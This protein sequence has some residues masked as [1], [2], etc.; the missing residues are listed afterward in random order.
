MI[1]ICLFNELIMC[2]QGPWGIALFANVLWLWFLPLQCIPALT[3]LPR[4]LSNCSATL[5]C[6]VTD[7]WVP[8]VL[9]VMDVMGTTC[10]EGDGFGGYYLSCNAQKAEDLSS[11]FY[12]S[13]FSFAPLSSPHSLVLAAGTSSVSP[14]GD[15]FSVP[16]CGAGAGSWHVGTWAHLV[17]AGTSDTSRTNM[18]WELN[19]IYPFP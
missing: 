17:D 13:T 16:M 1:C 9:E 5:L 12:T 10:P 4:M 19:A 11:L 8:P 2:F 7:G 14:P 18:M 6:S 15:T 3:I